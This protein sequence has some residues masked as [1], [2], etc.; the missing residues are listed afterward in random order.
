MANV[1]KLVLEND[2][3]SGSES[4]DLIAAP[5]DLATDGWRQK[6]ATD[7]SEQ[8]DEVI[9]LNIQD[10][11]M[12]AIAAAIATLDKKIDQA[13]RFHRDGAHFGV[14]LHAKVDGETN[15]RRALVMQARRT[16]EVQVKSVFMRQGIALPDYV[17]AARRTAFWEALTVGQLSDETMGVLGSRMVFASIAGDQPARTPFVFFFSSGSSGLAEF[18]LG[19][20]SDSKWGAAADFKPV[21]NLR[22]SGT[23]GTDTSTA[24][25]ST[26]EDGNKIVTTFA[27]QAAMVARATMRVRDAVGTT[28]TGIERKQRGRF[29]VLL[30]AYKTVGGDV[31]NVRL[32]SGFDASGTFAL[33]DRV[34][35]D[36]TGWKLYLLGEVEIPSARVLQNTIALESTAM[37]T[38]SLQVQAERI[39]G[40]GALHM[41]CLVLIPHDEGSIYVKNAVGLSGADRTIYVLQSADGM[42]NGYLVAADGT[43]LESS[44]VQ[45]RTWGVPIGDG[46]VIVAA[47]RVAGVSDKTDAF[48]IWMDY[49]TRYSSLRGA[50]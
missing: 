47:Q 45:P 25:D 42:M 37:G 10:S 21:W 12:N 39:S 27:T 17:F 22:N 1:L 46:Q 31:V 48:S 24:V 4:L 6:V 11:S 7:E 28:P 15:E 19:M 38:S 20:R 18:W 34:T 36:T 2:Y 29:M 32:G 33:Q 44:T 5:F 16:E 13:N 8:P 14:W 9:T 43:A 26:A 41:D 30:R 50:V 23:L 49:F 3:I 35:V 40:S